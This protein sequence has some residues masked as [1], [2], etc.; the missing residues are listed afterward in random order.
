MLEKYKKTILMICIINCISGFLI[1]CT[2]YKDG[3]MIHDQTD[4]D[5]FNALIEEIEHLKPNDIDMV[6]NDNP[7]SSNIENISTTK[8][9]VPKKIPI[10]IDGQV[11]NPGVY[12]IDEDQLINDLVLMAGGLTEEASLTFINLAATVSANSKVYIPK[13]DEEAPIVFQ[14]GVDTTL[15]LAPSNVSDSDDGLIQINN[16]TFAELDSLPNIGPSRANA[17]LSYIEQNG[18]FSDI[19]EIKNVSGIGDATLDGIKDFI[20]IN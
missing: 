9:S 13:F 6:S 11:V 16:A 1:G 15:D 10:H 4:K 17:I 20:I 2:R 7:D 19:D 12:M 8:N 18:G 14:G 3:L 5:D